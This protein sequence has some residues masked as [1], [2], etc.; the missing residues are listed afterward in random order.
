MRTG[1]TGSMKLQDAKGPETRERG[2]TSKGE[3][4]SSPSNG[5]LKS[6][7][8]PY[9]ICAAKASIVTHP[10]LGT[11]SLARW[12]TSVLATALFC[13]NPRCVK[14]IILFLHRDNMTFVRRWF[15]M[16]PGDEVRTI[17][18]TM[19]SSSFPWK[20]STLKTV[21]SHVRPPLFS[22]SSIAFRWAS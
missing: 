13:K 22:A 9:H 18:T 4:A 7:E 11:C 16:N 19:W 3:T 1:A 6:Q 10:V 15:T 2:N 8:P 12:P 5:S 17:E 20:E 14:I 21:F